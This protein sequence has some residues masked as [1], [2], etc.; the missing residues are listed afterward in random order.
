[1]ECENYDC[2][3]AIL[4]KELIP[5]MGCTEP[6]A[7]A[8]AA[9]LAKVTLGAF[10]EEIIVRTSG[11]IVKNAKGVVIP[12]SGGLK[13]LEAASILGVLA[14]DN[15]GKLDIL[16]SISPEARVKTLD[17]MKKGFCKSYLAE[18]VP[19]LYIEIQVFASDQSA[20][21][22]VKDGHTNVSLIEKNGRIEFEKDDS[23]NERREDNRDCLSVKKIID[24]ATKEDLSAIIPILDRQIKLNTEIA[25]EGMD[26]DYGA[27]VGRRLIKEGGQGIKN[28]AK[29]HAAAGADARMG[30]SPRPVIINSGSGNQGI[31]VSVPVIEYAKDMGVSYETLYRALAISNLVSIHIKS[32]IGSLSAF[33]GAV[34]A[35][36]GAGAAI[37]YLQGG[38]YDEISR[39][40]INT[41]GNV[42]GIICDGA[43]ASCAAKIAASL[44][45][46][47]M[48]TSMSFE[49][50]GFDSGDGIVGQD[51][52]ET[53]K[54]LGN[55]GGEGM[56]CTD[57][58]IIKVMTK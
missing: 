55:V 16:D 17:L 39:T 6:A 14:S 51:V 11:N 53:I 35:S 3:V 5:A 45:A 9:N 24:Y 18:D 54:N 7:V 44:D 36:C 46:A 40:I 43:K 49:K 52:E 8:Y 13:G 10:P 48:A 42:S 21:V 23:P 19:S 50:Y 27:S 33:C 12:N 26:Y 4:E 25:Q 22:I 57:R 41:I 28:R 20:R 30:G 2:M 34:S 38:A 58:E 31:T 29:A 1:M 37:S 32:H 15:S 56:K 47:F